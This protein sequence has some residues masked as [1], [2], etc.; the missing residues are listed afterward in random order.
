VHLRSI[1]PIENKIA[2]LI[3][4]ASAG[5]GQGAWHARLNRGLHFSERVA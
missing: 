4:A 5:A 1:A 2:L 3:L